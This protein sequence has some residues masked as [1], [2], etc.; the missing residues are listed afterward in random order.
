M[1]RFLLCLLSLFI[2]GCGKP[3]APS[4][5]L[6]L[7]SVDT[8]RADRLPFY[9]HNRATA[10]DVDELGTPAWLANNGVVWENCWAPA[11]KTLPSLGTFWT[12][13]DPLEH[14]GL[15]NRHVVTGKSVAES[16]QSLGFA[17]HA[18]V[19]NLSLSPACGLARGF[20]SY[21]VLAREQEPK[22]P[23]YLLSKAEMPIA[24][25][26]SLLL[27]AHFMAPH[28]PYSPPAFSKGTWSDLSGPPG[29]HELIGGVHRN[30]ATLTPELRAHLRGLYDEEILA[31]SLW[32]QEF[33][34]GLDSFYR[35][36]GR[37]GL[38]D[39]ARVVF[40]SDHG[41]ELGDRLGYFPHAKSLYSGVIRVPLAVA[42]LGVEQGKRI[43]E[44]LGLGHVLPH[45][46]GEDIDAGETF[47][48]SWFGEFF[49]VR[50]EDW[51]LIHNPG[52]DS[53]GPREPPRDVPYPYPD[54]A[55]FNRRVD[56]LEQKN[57]ASD[58]PEVTDSLLRSLYQWYGNLKLVE[59]GVPEGL[60]PSVLAELGYPESLVGSAHVPWP[61]REGPR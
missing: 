38:L 46:L 50:E 8:L 3:S 33:L 28:Q 23:R 36:A 47:F 41:E 17:T 43:Q 22:I 45:V 53:F 52:S 54:F 27:W 42:G 14:G 13:L 44:S 11:G 16:F 55:L 15:S 12:G 48:S 20:D 6:I 7:V 31:T 40:F 1:H 29:N 37:G 21:V 2:F 34:A 61:D 32:I 4:W 26:E 5:D 57:V 58:Y 9:G 10:G 24:Q 25:G 60:D 59:P 18:A 56:P 19:A 30:P 49:S 39:N 51:T 35:N